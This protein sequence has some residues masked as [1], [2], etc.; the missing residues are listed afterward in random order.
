MTNHIVCRMT[1]ISVV[2][3]QRDGS[4][5]SLKI[6]T[7]N[8]SELYKRAGFKSD[9]DFTV[10]C[11]FRMKSKDY[12]VV[13]YGKTKGKANSEN[14]YD[15]P[16]PVDETL[17]FG[18]CVL[19]KKT[20]DTKEP[21]NLTP[22]DWEANYE[23]LFGG[24]ENL[25]GGGLGMVVADAMDHKLDEMEM[26]EEEKRI[27][28]DP[29]T[30]FT[31][32]GYIKDGFIVDSDSDEDADY[33]ES[34]EDDSDTSSTDDE[35]DTR[36]KTNLQLRRQK[37]DALLSRT[38]QIIP[39][40]SSS[41][42]SEPETSVQYKQESTKE[43]PLFSFSGPVEN[44]RPFHANKSSKGKMISMKDKQNK[45]GKTPAKPKVPRVARKKAISVPT[46]VID[47]SL[48]RIEVECKD[49][50]VEEEY[51]T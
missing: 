37:L 22:A 46:C 45:R 14:K 25:D 47:Q 13:L 49:E 28:N 15:F 4:L 20:K 35:P 3:V 9:S 32:N 30:K 26:D 2:I 44:A 23:F 42:P 43:N 6:N 36:A 38:D 41:T 1:S 39:S 16:P 27:M 10:H 12:V 5:K 51:F 18:N 48:D 7:W 17:F 24:F 33:D 11:E 34:D 31:K 19:V 40:N 29:K 8:E 21:C 50:L